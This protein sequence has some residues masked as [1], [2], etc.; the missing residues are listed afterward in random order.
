MSSSMSFAALFATC[1]LCAVGLGAH[2]AGAQG[3]AFGLFA[4]LT[5]GGGLIC[6]FERS[7]V[8]SAFALLSTTWEPPG[9]SSCW[10][11]TT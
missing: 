3:A 6:L 8:R 10:A 7:V 11:R 4:L 1:L 9:C 2:Y 5:I